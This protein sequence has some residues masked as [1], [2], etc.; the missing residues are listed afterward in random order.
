MTSM[1]PGYV[2]VAGPF[3]GPF[4]WSKVADVLRQRGERVVVRD[5][6]DIALDSPVVLVAHSGGG[7]HLPRLAAEMPGVVGMVLVDALLPHPGRSWAQTVPD[8]FAERLTSQ[9][10]DG[11]LPPWPEWWGEERMRELVPDDDLRAAFVEAC[12][13]VPVGTLDEVMPEVP[14]PPG[15]F[16]QLSETYAPESESARRRGWPVLTLDANHLALLTDPD[17]VAD[18]VVSAAAELP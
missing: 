1:R 11:R 4:A 8:A 18:A 10:V 15:V 2:L 9:A 6:D 12:P 5:V 14:D 16:V 17:A 3:T 7:P 13:A